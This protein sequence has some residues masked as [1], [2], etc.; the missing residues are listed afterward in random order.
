MQLAHAES[1]VVLL[2]LPQARHIHRHSPVSAD[3]CGEGT[4]AGAG[5]DKAG[6]R[7]F[8]RKV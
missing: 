8:V 7:S 5:L 6:G 4:A 2:V 1:V 3:I